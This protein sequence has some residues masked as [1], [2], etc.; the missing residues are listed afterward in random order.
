VRWLA[1]QAAAAEAEYGPS[2]EEHGASFR[3]APIR[4]SHLLEVGDGVELELLP[5]DPG[6]WEWWGEFES[7]LEIRQ[8][9][10]FSGQWRDLVDQK[11]IESWLQ[12]EAE[13]YLAKLRHGPS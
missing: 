13:R 3:V 9:R 5:R 4:I 6:K 8:R 11:G 1:E 12:A 2:F 10:R 7:E